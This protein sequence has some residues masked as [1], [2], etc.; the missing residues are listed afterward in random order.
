MIRTPPRSTR[1]DTLFPY[2]TL[3]RSVFELNR[4]DDERPTA[5]P[6]PSSTARSAAPVTPS[7]APPPTTPSSTAV[8]TVTTSDTSGATP[9][10]VIGADCL[11]EGSTAV[12]AAGATAYCSSIQDTDDT[13]W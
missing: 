10:V 6:P 4:A 12:T 9:P 7:A 3:F 13:V 11:P 5:A 2:T 1:T 8:T